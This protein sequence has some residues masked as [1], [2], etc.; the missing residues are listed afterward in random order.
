MKQRIDSIDIA[1]GIA[2]LL[3][4]IQH[5]GAYSQFLL[6]FHM[7]LFFMVSGMVVMGEK[8]R[9]SILQEVYKNTKRLLIPQLTLGLCE[10]VF[11]VLSTFYLEHEFRMLEL[12]QI[13]TAILRWWFLLVLFQCRI[14]IWFIKKYV[15]GTR[16]CEIIVFIVLAALSLF[17]Y[18]SPGHF[19]ILPLYMNLV[20]LCLMFILIGYYG[21][22]YLLREIKLKEAFVLLFLLAITII[23]S[24]INSTVALYKYELGNILLFIISSIAGSIFFIKI[25]TIIK[26]KLMR[27]IGIMCMPIYV[28]QFH[29]TQYSRAIEATILDSIGCDDMT[30]KLTVVI[31]ISIFACCA[32]TW[33]VSKNKVTKLLFGVSN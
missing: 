27:W 25:A 30:I 14:L 31:L 18:Y 26:S 1:R 29:V 10:C 6:S 2:M 24:Q 3:V 19:R 8:P 15:F 16:S 7:P 21:K 17:V 33:V 12:N 9:N 32:L 22:E 4:I 20:P 23:V 13:V 28:L 5:C 11:L